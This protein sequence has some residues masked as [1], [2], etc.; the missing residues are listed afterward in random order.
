MSYQKR[1]MIFLTT[2]VVTAVILVAFF[3]R[4]TVREFKSLNASSIPLPTLGAQDKQKLHDLLQMPQK[5]G[6]TTSGDQSTPSNTTS[7]PTQPAQEPNN[8]Q[9]SVQEIPA[10]AMQQ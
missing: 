9:N 4:F 2:M 6:T 10:K 7:A 8:T 5:S 3:V 1:V